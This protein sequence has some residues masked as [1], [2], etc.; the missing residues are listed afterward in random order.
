MDQ[1]RH[2][3][4][5]GENWKTKHIP[6]KNKQVLRITHGLFHVSPPD[7]GITYASALVLH[8]STYAQEAE[9]L[10]NNL[11]TDKMGLRTL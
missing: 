9:K 4:T 11:R 5:K 8:Q 10:K 7:A 3:D 2:K 6:A 1:T